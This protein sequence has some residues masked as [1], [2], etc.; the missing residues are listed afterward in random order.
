MTKKLIA[1]G[2]LFLL[3]SHLIY[4]QYL[5]TNE[6]ES[7][8]EKAV[9][10][11]VDSLY[12]N[13]N[14]KPLLKQLKNKRIVLLGEFN[15]GS[16]EVFVARNEL[17]K[18]L[19]KNLGFDVI[20]FES[21]IGEL[22]PMDIFR[23]KISSKYMTVGLFGGWRTQEFVQLMDYVKNENI[24]INGFDIQRTGGSF[25]RLLEIV[26]KQH[27]IDTT[28]AQKFEQRFTSEKRKLTNKKVSF[29]SV[30]NSTTALISDYSKLQKLLTNGQPNT[31]DKKIMLVQKT[32]EN[33]IAFLSYQLNFKKDGDWNRRWKARDVAMAQNVEWLIETLY[34]NRKVIIIGHNF[35][36]ARYNEN[37]EVMGEF[38]KQKYDAE[39]YSIGVFARSGSYFDN[40]GNEKKMSPD[41]N[42]L[43]IKHAIGALDGTLNFLDIQNVSK[44][45]FSWLFEKVIVNDTFID[46]NGSNEM[47]LSKHF[48]G[49][50]LFD[51]ISTPTKIE[52]D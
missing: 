32:I 36:I 23:K 3:C 9:D 24:S 15:H 31:T 14:W 46:L 35:H 27:N 43:G 38:L 8:R 28:Q 2:G 6:V 50:L 19:H 16:K 21:G 34:A 45:G 40:S 11:E 22:A 33:R 7:L 4:G 12:E 26:L 13:G 5:T 49:L 48:D 47:I 41:A 30:Q 37:E 25:E 51:T 10:I 20:L 42:Q 29:D 44:K 39:M 18:Y 17:I 1:L 52:W